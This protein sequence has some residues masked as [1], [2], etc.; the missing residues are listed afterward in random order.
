MKAPSNF[1]YNLKT[2]SCASQ[3]T[4]VNMPN[5]GNKQL[6]ERVAKGWNIKRNSEAY[7]IAFLLG[8]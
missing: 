6:I 1:W 4:S 5:N 7:V 2:W 8:F 3:N